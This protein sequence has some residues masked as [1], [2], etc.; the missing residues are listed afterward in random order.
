M[1][2]IILFAAVLLFGV[3]IFIAMKK[4]KVKSEGQPK[5]NYDDKIDRLVDRLDNI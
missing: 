4:K 5:H 3:M 1:N 2:E